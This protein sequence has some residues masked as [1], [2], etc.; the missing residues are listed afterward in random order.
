MA[1]GGVVGSMFP[2]PGTAV[3]ITVGGI[4]GGLAGGYLF[5][6]KIE[7]SYAPPPR[8]LEN[9]VQSSAFGAALPFVGGTMP[10]AGN[11]IWMGPVVESHHV[12]NEHEGDVD[13]DI[14]TQSWTA[15]FAVAFCQ[16][17]AA[18]IRR[19]WLDNQLIFD[20]SDTTGAYYPVPGGFIGEAY[21]NA[22]LGPNTFRYRVYYGSELQG[23]DPTIAAIEGAANTQAFRGVCY[24]VLENFNVGERGTL[25]NLEA[26]VV[27][28]GSLTASQALIDLDNIGYGINMRSSSHP[29][30]REGNYVLCDY[31]NHRFIILKR[32]SETVLSTF[33]VP[34][35]AAGGLS[36]YQISGWGISPY[37]GWLWVCC[38]GTGYQTY[39]RRN[40]IYS[41]PGGSLL[42]DSG[43]Q[44]VN[45]ASAPYAAF[46]TNY[47][48]ESRAGQVWEQ[49]VTAAGG[50]VEYAGPRPLN[51]TAFTTSATSNAGGYG[52]FR[53]Y[54][55][56]GSYATQSAVN[57]SCDGTYFYLATSS[58][59][60]GTG[61]GA[62][63]HILRVSPLSIYTVSGSYPNWSFA[64]AYGGWTILRH[65]IPDDLTTFPAEWAN[66]SNY[67]ATVYSHVMG[68]GPLSANHQQA[69]YT[70]PA[71]QTAVDRAYITP[72]S[73]ALGTLI[74]ELC[75]MGG[76]EESEIDVSALSGLEVLGY[77]VTRQ[78]PARAAIEP[79][80]VGYNVDCGEQDW[81]LRFA[82]RGGSSA[83]SIPVSDLA[84]RTPGDPEADRLVE[85][86][87]QPVELPT[88]LTLNYLSRD[89]DY[90]R[91]SHTSFRPDLPGPVPMSIDVP[92]VLTDAQALQLVE[93]SHKILYQARRKYR[94]S[95]SIKY[96]RLSPADPATV[97]G[98]LMRITAVDYRLPLLEF[99]AESEE[100]GA[101]TG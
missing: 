66:G 1:L 95:T 59:D 62:T 8:L 22:A 23:A 89:Q 21:F 19:I 63:R 36:I 76:L 7:T 41:S 98:K 20:F 52:S 57:L 10:L 87:Q 47:F 82:P 74:S 50:W 96:V 64:I 53:I 90:E 71:A 85:T 73:V 33:T 101:Y 54:K 55:S 99:S 27:A 31:Q 97:G 56:D 12:D 17:P 43:D 40:L 9:R 86:I 15:S 61:L 100:G 26:E 37:S 75:Q 13:Y 79:L 49:Y 24:M 93:Q 6:D 88:M 48:F 65:G 45:V 80:L 83:A 2:G 70:D 60:L 30:T 58:V 78:M 44:L 46:G 25:P 77:A 32:F 38:K 4:L 51:S 28:A 11:L 18:G 72:Q 29:W 34:A 92:L 5:G 84:A 3:G 35:V 67:P 91:A 69:L 81:Q 68:Q 42:Y 14:H 39:Y 16:G 94:F